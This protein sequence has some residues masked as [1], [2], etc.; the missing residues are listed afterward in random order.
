VDRGALPA[1][2]LFPTTS[3]HSLEKSLSP[4]PD[5][6]VLLYTASIT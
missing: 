4:L 5:P 2:K 3:S 6:G 1:E